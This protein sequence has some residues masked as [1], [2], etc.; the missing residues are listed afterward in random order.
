M[1]RVWDW[2]LVDL[3]CLGED[4]ITTVLGM[5]LGLGIWTPPALGNSAP[6]PSSA[7]VSP[8]AKQEE[9][10]LQLEILKIN[11]LIYSLRALESSGIP[12]NKSF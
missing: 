10:F 7:S 2:A 1:S 11:N 12:V 5:E 9:S 8:S 3:T 4:G 6:A